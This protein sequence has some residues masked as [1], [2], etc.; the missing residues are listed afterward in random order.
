[1]QKS[2]NRDRHPFFDQEKEQKGK[3]SI[4]KGFELNIMELWQGS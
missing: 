3:V 4:D 1:M 2:N